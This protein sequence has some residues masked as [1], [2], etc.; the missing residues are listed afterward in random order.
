MGERGGGGGEGER[1]AKERNGEVGRVFKSHKTDIFRP[2]VI[3]HIFLCPV[4]AFSPLL[5]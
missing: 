5:A 1:G 3:S 4:C 2:V